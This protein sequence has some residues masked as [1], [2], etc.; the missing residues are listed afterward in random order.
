VA[1]PLFYLLHFASTAAVITIGEEVGEVY[2][3]TKFTSIALSNPAM[4]PEEKVY[5]PKPNT[6]NMITTNKMK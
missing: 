6:A 2:A 4:S 1:E 5:H 3:K